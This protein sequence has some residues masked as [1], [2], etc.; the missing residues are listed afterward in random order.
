MDWGGCL[1]LCSTEELVKYLTEPEGNIL[2]DDFVSQLDP[3]GI[4]RNHYESY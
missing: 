4:C 1:C 2:V 3:V